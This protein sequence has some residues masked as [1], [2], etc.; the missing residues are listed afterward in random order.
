MYLMFKGF[1]TVALNPF[2]V[3]QVSVFSVKQLYSDVCGNK[4]KMPFGETYV[5][6][7]SKEEIDDENKRI[8]AEL[9]K[10][11]DELFDALNDDE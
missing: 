4:R 6:K 10:K 11:F 5:S 2:K 1:P 3:P 9:E 7:P 8:Q